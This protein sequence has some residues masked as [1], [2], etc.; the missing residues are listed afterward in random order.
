MEAR[1]FASNDDVEEF[2]LRR[3]IARAATSRIGIQQQPNRDST[4]GVVRQR[5]MQL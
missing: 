3:L 5:R 2:C 1:H 4:I